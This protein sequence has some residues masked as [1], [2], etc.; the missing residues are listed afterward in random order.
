MIKNYGYISLAMGILIVFMGFFFAFN[1][2]EV[3][4]NMGGYAPMLIGVILVMYG[5]LRISMAVKRLTKK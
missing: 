5:F 2:P 4:A 3:I 1:P